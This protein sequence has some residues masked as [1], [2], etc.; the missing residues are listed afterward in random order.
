M[1]K[2]SF[3]DG[4]YNPN[5]FV[6]IL[7]KYNN[8]IKTYKYILRSQCQYKFTKGPRKGQKCPKRVLINKNYCPECVHKFKEK[9]FFVNLRVS[10][11]HGCKY[12]FMEGYRKGQKCSKQIL[13]EE[14]YCLKCIKLNN[15]F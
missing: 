6:S 8:I 12:I 7:R 9:D 3:R 1:G 15:T 13:L 14:D 4:S 5:E 10:K 11:T 2:I